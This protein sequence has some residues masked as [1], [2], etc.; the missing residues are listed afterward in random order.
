MLFRIYVIYPAYFILFFYPAFL[1]HLWF[2]LQPQQY[3]KW[4]LNS[5]QL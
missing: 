5:N 3:F 4:I 2:I 1:L